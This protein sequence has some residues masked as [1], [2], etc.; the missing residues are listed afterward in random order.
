MVGVA[1]ILTLCVQ[2]N[3]ASA[4]QK[5]QLTR[6]VRRS[7]VPLTLGFVALLLVSSCS[8]SLGSTLSMGTVDPGAVCSPRGI[9]EAT[10]IAVDI[11]E[12]T[13]DDD[14]VIDGVSLDSAAG[15]QLLSS[16][17][18]K[19]LDGGGARPNDGKTTG[20]FQPTV[21]APGERGRLVVVL[22]GATP[23]SFGWANGMWVNAETPKGSMRIHTCHALIVAPGDDCGSSEDPK[24]PT[25]DFDVLRKLCGQ[26]ER[27]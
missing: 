11:V 27:T 22:Q 19:D 17:I 26:T 3:P 2:A 21:L 14:V 16:G 7:S 15:A 20:A 12:N 4:M 9:D 13:S 8:T 10:I 23:G 18:Q 1:A 6:K 24:Y 5:P 25:V